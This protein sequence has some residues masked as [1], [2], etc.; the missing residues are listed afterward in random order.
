MKKNNII[1]LA[2]SVLLAS[3]AS[4]KR[5]VIGANSNYNGITTLL[6]SV[7]KV[8]KKN[9][10]EF[11]CYNEIKTNK[12]VGVSCQ[13]NKGITYFSAGFTKEKPEFETH[14]KIL[15]KS[16]PTMIVDSI[17][18]ALY[19]KYITKKETYKVISKTNEKTEIKLKNNKIIVKHL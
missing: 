9:K 4:Y 17:T 10:E 14:N 18:I 11:I 1:I 7:S 19:D 13:N 2:L 12:L 5:N 16:S 3:C 15:Y 6:V 8:G